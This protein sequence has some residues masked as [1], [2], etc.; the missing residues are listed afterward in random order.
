VSS[1]DSGRFE[2]LVRTL[3]GCVLSKKIFDLQLDCEAKF[4]VPTAFTP[5]GDNKNPTLKIFGEFLTKLDFRIYNRWGEVVFAT[6]RKDD[7]WNGTVNGS[8]APAGVYIW[9]V[10]YQNS[11]KRGA[12]FKKSGQITLIR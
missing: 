11:L 9:Q 1:A 2:V 5:N 6:T 4:F 3:E 8:S 10:T 7:E 12:T